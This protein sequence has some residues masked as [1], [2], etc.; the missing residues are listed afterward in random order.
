MN[1]TPQGREN[2]RHA[3]ASLELPVRFK[4]R[5]GSAIT[6]ELAPIDAQTRNISA[7]GMFI[8]LG[9]TRVV[10]GQSMTAESFLLLKAEMDI[11][12][13]LQ[14][15]GQPIQTTGKAVW[16]EKPVEGQEFKHGV[17]VQFFDITDEDRER[18]AQTVKAAGG[19]L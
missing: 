7:G 13:D 12:L 19:E 9:Q 14:D 15:G 16:V 6:S 11:T 3:R 18:I 2:R 10:P 17:A 8:D 1:D 4:L 5:G